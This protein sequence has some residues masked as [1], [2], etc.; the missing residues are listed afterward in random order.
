MYYQYTYI[1]NSSEPI[2]RNFQ[3]NG[4]LLLGLNFEQNSHI[5]WFFCSTFDTSPVES[6]WLEMSRNWHTKSQGPKKKCTNFFRGR[7]HSR[8]AGTARIQG[9][10]TSMALWSVQSF[11]SITVCRRKNPQWCTYLYFF[12]EI[13][14][15][16]CFM[17]IKLRTTVLDREWGSP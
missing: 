6:I 10:F 13:L 17:K 7:I 2:Y 5:M 3:S 16:G 1:M 8:L 9:T 12:S 14:H 15:R 11:M 4:A